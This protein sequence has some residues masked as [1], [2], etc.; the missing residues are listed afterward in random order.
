MKGKE[1]N[2]AKIASRESV[3]QFCNDEPECA[4]AA[5]GDAW[6]IKARGVV[7]DA[8]PFDAESDF[9]LAKSS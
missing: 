6:I 2:S 4:G 5:T 7:A 1:L 9:F 8:D 3:W